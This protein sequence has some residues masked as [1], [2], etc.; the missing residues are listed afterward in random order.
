MKMT[1]IE[2]IEKY[3]SGN[4]ASFASACGVKPQQIT[5]WINGQFIVVDHI[6]YSPRRELPVTSYS[7]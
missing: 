6:L 2:Y 1:L 5:K 7:E 3:Y 4:Q